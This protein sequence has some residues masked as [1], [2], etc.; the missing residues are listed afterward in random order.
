MIWIGWNP[1]PFFERMEPSVLGVLERVEAASL[2]AELSGSV[3]LGE[4]A[5]ATTEFNDDEDD[6]RPIV[7]GDE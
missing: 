7:A 4:T 5:T 3:E 6:D 2:G 1:T